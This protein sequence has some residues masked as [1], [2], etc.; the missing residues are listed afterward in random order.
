MS[1]PTV[2]PFPHIF[3]LLYRGKKLDQP[4]VR[5]SEILSVYFR[6]NQL[7]FVGFRQNFNTILDRTKIDNVGYKTL[8]L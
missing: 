3:L 7:N 2:N 6:Q 4:P 1:A 5:I 8:H